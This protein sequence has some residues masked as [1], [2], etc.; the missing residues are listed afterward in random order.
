M[1]RV[2]PLPSNWTP[3]ASTHGCMLPCRLERPPVH[4][5][6]R[7][8]LDA[9]APEL[10]QLPISFIRHQIT[11]RAPQM[12]AGLDDLPIP[13]TIPRLHLPRKL[14]VPVPRG[15]G[16][17]NVECWDPTHVLALSLPARRAASPDAPFVLIPIHGIVLAAHCAAPVLGP[18]PTP[19]D[20]NSAN[21]TLVLPLC[22][23]IL[24]SVPA[25]LVLR[26]Y[27]YTQRLDSFLGAVLP[28]PEPFAHAAVKA[29]L[30]SSTEIKRLAAHLIDTHA[31][32]AHLLEYV[33]RVRDVWQTMCRLGMHHVQLWNALDLAWDILMVA[34]NTAGNEAEEQG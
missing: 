16:A 22:P 27:M 30:A 34:L 26:A 33:G 18:A 14:T 3:S 29:A 21:G 2:A 8:T 6:P 13:S 17:D 32:L 23:V 28:L 24:P 19:G 20:A 12:L 9:L 4:A 7:A 25:L 1:Y 31:S 15:A 11:L 5:A 10:A